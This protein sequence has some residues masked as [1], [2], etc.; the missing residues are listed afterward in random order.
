MFVVIIKSFFWSVHT[1]IL[2]YLILQRMQF[3]SLTFVLFG[4]IIYGRK[5]KLQGEKSCR[6]WLTKQSR[7]LWEPCSQISKRNTFI[8]FSSN[9]RVPA[10]IGR[11]SMVSTSHLK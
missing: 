8:L 6:F 3:D 9:R 2:A 5:L 10:I 7:A 11:I 4:Y 1:K